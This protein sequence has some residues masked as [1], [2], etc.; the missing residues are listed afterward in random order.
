MSISA[1]KKMNALVRGYIAS[2]SDHASNNIN[3]ENIG[4]NK[5]DGGTSS[6]L[7]IEKKSKET[8][9]DDDGQVRELDELEMGGCE[10]NKYENRESLY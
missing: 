7:D 3:I 10:K 2:V 4:G 9:G 6:G 5:K 1:G 8:A